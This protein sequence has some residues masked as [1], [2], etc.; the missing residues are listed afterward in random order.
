VYHYQKKDNVIYRVNGNNELSF[1]SVK[2][3]C[4]KFKSVNSVKDASY[5]RRSKT[6]TFRKKLLKKN[7][8]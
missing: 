8:I 1:S 3:L 5:A 4:K 6:A 7:R 2:R